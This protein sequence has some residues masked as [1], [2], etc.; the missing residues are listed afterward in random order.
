MI[1]RAS[2]FFIG[3]IAMASL[4]VA[5]QEKPET[6]VVVSDGGTTVTQ[7]ELRYI[8]EHW[9]PELHQAA[10]HDPGDRIELL[11]QVLAI[12]KIAEQ[13]DDLTAEADGDLYWDL[14]MNIRQLKQR[15]MVKHYIENLEVPDMTDLAEERYETQKAKYAHVKEQRTSSHILVLCDPRKCD[16]EKEEKRINEVLAKL[17]AGEKFEDLAKQYSEDP[18][19]KDKGGKFNLWM[20]EDST[21]V[22]NIYLKTVFK[23]EEAG[24]VSGV[25][26]S[27]FGFHIIRLDGIKPAFDRPYEEVKSKII[28]DLET[29]YKQLSVKAYDDKFRFSDDYFIDNAAVD[30]L[31]APYVSEEE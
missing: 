13:A 28:A 18:G 9:G 19:S 29:E 2:I 27:Q 10:A 1:K 11:N 25:V 3:L 4:P 7:D 6:K 31:L 21:K 26:R 16:G 30:Q 8:I 22:D 24:D 17:E 15:F 5:A 14:Q 20:D 12:K 23:L